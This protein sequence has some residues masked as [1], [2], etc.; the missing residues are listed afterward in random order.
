MSGLPYRNTTVIHRPAA[1][2]ALL[3]A[4]T[5]H[6]QQAPQPAQKPKVYALVASVGD[7]FNFIREEK[8]TGTNLSPFKRQQVQVPGNELNKLVLASLDQS[9]AKTDPQ[10]ERLFIAMSPPGVR[11]EALVGEALVDWVIEQLK[12]MPQSKDWDR[13]LLATQGYRVMARERMPSRLR[14]MGVFA[15]PLCQGDPDSCERGWT[16]FT[17]AE[18]VTPEGE[19]IQAN[20]FVAPYSLIDVWVIDPKTMT[21]VDRGEAHE[22]TKMYD[23]KSAAIDIYANIETK[24]MAERIVGLVQS[25]VA[26]AVADAEGRGT[27]DVRMTKEVKP[28]EK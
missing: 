28:G 11:K 5:A 7:Q 27:V 24:V 6:A 10:S 9:V 25:S 14:G 8:S 23:P 26:A 17:G 19:R 16:P 1:L 18:A 2:A 20:H 15:Q 21:V 12:A 22:H 3:L 13:V 4:C